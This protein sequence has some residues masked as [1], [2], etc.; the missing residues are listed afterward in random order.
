MLD[1]IGSIVGLS[2]DFETHR[3]HITFSMDR[4]TALQCVENLRQSDKLQV[5]VTKFRRKRSLDANNYMWAL[6]SQIG[7]KLNLSKDEVYEKMLQDYGTFYK[8]DDGYISVTVK[9]AVDMAKLGGHWKFIKQVGDFSSYL[10]IKGSSEYDTKEM[11]QLL[12][13]VV[14]EA[15]DLG[16]QTETQF[17]LERMLE[18]WGRQYQSSHRT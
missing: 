9:S 2:Q 18:E 3:W 12:D 5:H 17:D 15:Q 10:M 11:A 6:C 4:D 14:R 8:D 16:I 7:H 13:G 1:F